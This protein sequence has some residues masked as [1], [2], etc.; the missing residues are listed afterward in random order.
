MQRRGGCVPGVCPQ[1]G[2]Q[3]QGTSLPWRVAPRGWFGGGV[4][5]LWAVF[6]LCSLLV[7]SRQKTPTSRSWSSSRRP[8]S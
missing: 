4:L 7:P 6:V 8:L 1:A 5:Y 2:G 3:R